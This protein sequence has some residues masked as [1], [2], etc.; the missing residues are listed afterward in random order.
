MVSGHYN[1][2]GFD[3]VALSITGK[4]RNIQFKDN[5]L[6]ETTSSIITK[7][8]KEEFDCSIMVGTDPISH[9]PQALST[10]LATK[11]I[12]LIDNKKTATSQ[13]A[14]VILP[15]SITGIESSGLAFRLDNVPIEL[16]KIINPPNNLLSDED[17]LNAIIKKLEA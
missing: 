7:I 9:L 2:N 14:D 12:I 17:I 11:P 8:S 1:M 10:K 5:N 3:Q 16:K 6:Q 4:D 13:L 15:T